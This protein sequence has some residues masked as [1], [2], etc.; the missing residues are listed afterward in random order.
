MALNSRYR[1]Q[2][3]ASQQLKRAAGVVTGLSGVALLWA[4]AG[5]VVDQEKLIA[6]LLVCMSLWGLATG[7]GLLRLQPWS[8]FSMLVFHSLL[9]ICAVSSVVLLAVLA[10]TTPN[11]GIVSVHNFGLAMF[12]TAW[13]VLISVTIGVRGLLFFRRNDIRTHF[14]GTR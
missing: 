8:R 3:N 1:D 14:G 5:L 6:V 12:V 13:F 10:L 4:V 2:P 11:K 7:V 9:C